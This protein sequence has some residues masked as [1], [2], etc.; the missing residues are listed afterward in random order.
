VDIEPGIQVAVDTEGMETALRNLFENA[1]LYSPAAPDIKVTLRTEGRNC[2]LDFT[3]HGMGI[4]KEDARKIFRMFYRVRQPGENIRGT[5]LGLYI[6]ASVASEHG[7]KV[8][9][10]S[11]GL[12][13]GCTFTITLPLAGPK[14]A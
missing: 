6:V 11:E 13:R 2:R 4:A 14:E 10:T 9:V 12:G 5:G 8:R 7:G 3:D 1:V